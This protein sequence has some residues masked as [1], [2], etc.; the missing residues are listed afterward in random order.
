MVTMIARQD[1]AFFFIPWFAAFGVIVV[2]SKALNFDY[3]ELAWMLRA[4][5]NLGTIIM[6]LL[7]AMALQI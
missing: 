6:C 7:L 5:I 3:S 1:V 4:A 2:L